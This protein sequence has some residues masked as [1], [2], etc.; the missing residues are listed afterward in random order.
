[1]CD[2]RGRAR[3]GGVE[4]NER[5]TAA[6]AVVLIVL[7][8]VEGVTILFRQPL[9]SAHVFVG[10]LLIPPVAVKLAS[11]GYRFLRYYQRRRAY[12]AKGPPNPLMRFVVAPVLVVSTVGIFASGVA[13]F[14]LGRRTGL[15]MGVHK[16]SFVVWIFAMGI[17]V[18]VYLRRLPALL[19]SERRTRGA[20]LRVGTLGAA[21]AAGLV[22]ATVTLPLARPWLHRSHEEEGD[23]ARILPAAPATPLG[24]ASRRVRR[25]AG[26]PAT[27][28]ARALGLPPVPPGPVPGYVL[29][30]DRNANKLLIV[31]PSKRIVWQFPRPGDLRPG[32]SFHDPDDAFFVP[33]F[34]RIVTNEEFNDTIAQIDVR[35]HRLVWSYGHAGVAGAAA[36]ELS[37][38]DDAYVWPNRTITVAD[39]RNCRVLRLSPAGRTIGEIGGSGCAHDPP[40]S[41]SSPNG[42]TPLPDGGMLV[43]EIGGWVDRLDE[44]G[45]LVF[46]V[47]TP[48]TYPSDAQ[49]LPDGNLLV[50]GFD[51]PGRV[52]EITP[53]GRIVWTYGPQSGPGALDRPSLAVRWPNGMI[54][55]TDDWHHRIVVVDPRSKRI[56][57]QYGRLGVPSAADGY[58]SKPDGLDLLPAGLTSPPRRPPLA[59]RR[60][61]TLPAPES[62]LAAA[63]LG[64]G[65]VVVAGGLAGGASSRSVLLGPPQ[66]LRT[67][68]TLPVATHDAALA[69]SGSAA[70]LLG[71]GEA[72]STDAVVRID[73]RTGAT[74]PAGSLGEPLS[75]LGAVSAGGKA[76]LVG[77][78][79][80]TR[81]AT[82]VLR[83]RPGGS[84]ALV[85]RLPSGLRYAGVAAI[86]GTIYVAGGVTTSGETDAVLSV[87]P[88]RHSVRLV[89]RL[90]EPVAH[91]P[92]AA[93]RGSLYLVG[94]TGAAGRPLDGIL[95]IDPSSGTVT[96]A[97]RL[98]EPLADSA[99][100][101]AG[102]RVIVLG[103]AG[104]SAS[105][106]VLALEPRR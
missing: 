81:F 13:M 84:P 83:F 43:T 45:R 32:Q 98:P 46:S 61:G 73:P 78:Y 56:V 75:D 106:A 42:A 58:L 20:T 50:A 16:A 96:V 66:R 39:I 97:G 2:V 64:D 24:P 72:V 91:A 54:A 94:G 6:T 55:I 93:L 49:L 104:A 9:L 10:M 8:A 14:A 12:V 92:L 60:I 101:A 71:G 36:G 33:G 79:T 51:T 80:G 76:Y 19:F 1:M 35:T 4:G 7:L 41:L 86:G 11:T 65:R 87:D 53:R 105:S 59:V 95:R 90:P 85:A 62:R 30:A 63:G 88:H 70:Y 67:A 100:V 17:H 82:A 99:A 57:W 37:N 40:G 103:G 3:T 22:V 89:A 77:G 47:R 15:V 26:A 21:L 52:D 34:R 5:L 23:A 31:S 102:G 29:I 48:T 28:A 38:P 18:L 44:R 68:G 74:R 27:P 69:L 25:V